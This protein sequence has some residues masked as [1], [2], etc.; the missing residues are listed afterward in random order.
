MHVLPRFS[1][2]YTVEPNNR[3]EYWTKQMSLQYHYCLASVDLLK[4][5]LYLYISK[6]VHSRLLVFVIMS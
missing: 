4:L 6:C 2:R 5:T 3:I 1:L